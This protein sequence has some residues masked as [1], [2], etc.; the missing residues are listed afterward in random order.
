M[1]YPPGSVEEHRF[2][3]NWYRLAVFLEYLRDPFDRRGSKLLSAVAMIALSWCVAHQNDTT[4]LA[5]FFL[6]PFISGSRGILLE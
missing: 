5:L 6:M 4:L 2:E 1:V 3:V